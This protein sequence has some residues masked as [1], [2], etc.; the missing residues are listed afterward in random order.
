MRNEN[1]FNILNKDLHEA[2]EGL[3]SNVLGLEKPSIDKFTDTI[4]NAFKE[5]FESVY[6]KDEMTR[7]GNNHDISIMLYITDTDGTKVTLDMTHM[8]VEKIES[9]TPF[10]GH[11]HLEKF[12][13]WFGRLAKNESFDMN[14]LNLEFKL[15]YNGTVYPTWKFKAKPNKYVLDDKMELYLTE[16]F[17]PVTAETV[18]CISSLTGDIK[19]FTPS[20]WLSGN[21]EV[22]AKGIASLHSLEITTYDGIVDFIVNDK[23]KDVEDTDGKRAIHDMLTVMVKEWVDLAKSKRMKTPALDTF[24]DITKIDIVADFIID[25][26]VHMGLQGFGEMTY[27]MQVNK[28]TDIM[29]FEKYLAKYND[30]SVLTRGHISTFFALPSDMI[31]SCLCKYFKVES[32]PTPATD[33]RVYFHSIIWGTNK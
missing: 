13:V 5:F 11:T 10:A 14:S 27:Y 33:Y 12:K 3:K 28:I 2:L 7:F 29:D 4:N 8:Y 25:C 24:I 31:E 21:E 23:I 22:V 30:F 6:E 16:G 18:R 15:L 20:K 19:E 26:I 17:V 1:N 9:T 32:Y